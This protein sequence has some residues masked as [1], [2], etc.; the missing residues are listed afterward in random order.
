M[1][2]K[3][4]LSA[5]HFEG[6][7]DRFHINMPESPNN[8]VKY[9]GWAVDDCRLSKVRVLCITANTQGQLKLKVVKGASTTLLNAPDVNIN[10]TGSSG[11]LT[12]GVVFTATLTGTASD[13]DFAGGD[14]WRI[15]VSS[16]SAQMDASGIYVELLFEVG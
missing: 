14:V 5:T 9:Y 15:E 10:A 6:P 4:I 13:L 16:N 12:D 11:V 1:S 8:T 7:V 2:V 3:N